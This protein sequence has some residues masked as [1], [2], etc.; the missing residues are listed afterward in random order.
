MTNE[1]NKSSDIYTYT[2]VRSGTKKRRER[3]REK[4]KIINGDIPVCPDNANR[5]LEMIMCLKS[6]CEQQNDTDGKL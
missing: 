2:Q 4:E 5:K 6:P 3:E 1:L